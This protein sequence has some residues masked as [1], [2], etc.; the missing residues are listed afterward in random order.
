MNPAE[1]RSAYSNTT[2]AR[3]YKK[4]MKSE[5][6]YSLEPI[7]SGSTENSVVLPLFPVLRNWLMVARE[8]CALSTPYVE[9]IALP[10]LRVSRT[11]NAV[12][13]VFAVCFLCGRPDRLRMFG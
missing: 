12:F 5:V 8:S 11:K 6:G 2:S 9:M 3:S 7:G 4:K 13:A 1:V 10:A